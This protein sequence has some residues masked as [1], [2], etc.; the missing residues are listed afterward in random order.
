MLHRKCDESAQQKMNKS[1]ASQGE[2]NHNFDIAELPVTW[3]FYDVAMGGSQLVGSF[4][5]VRGEWERCEKIDTMLSKSARWLSNWT[6][7][8]LFR[9]K[10]IMSLSSIMMDTVFL[11]VE[12]QMS[13]FYSQGVYE[14]G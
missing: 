11:Q 3:S 6:D 13:N 10:I 12:S 2:A 9:G 7:C 8:T 14:S 1:L 4:N 5:E